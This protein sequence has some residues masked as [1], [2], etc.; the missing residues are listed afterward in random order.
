MGFAHE[1]R[2]PDPPTLRSRLSRMTNVFAAGRRRGED[3]V[4]HD[5]DVCELRGSN[6]RL[7]RILGGM[8]AMGAVATFVVSS[9][10]FVTPADGLAV[11]VLVFLAIAALVGAY[12]NRRYRVVLSSPGSPLITRGSGSPSIGPTSSTWCPSTTGSWRCVSATSPRW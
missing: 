6:R 2:P 11:A 7:I 10:G 5:S 12:I 8:T 1:S 3:R 9:Q 4:D